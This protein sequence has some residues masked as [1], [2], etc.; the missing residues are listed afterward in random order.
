MATGYFPP[1]GGGSG[2]DDVTA[3]KNQLLAGYTAITS[4]SA[5]EPIEGTIPTR[6]AAN[7]TAAGSTVT[8]ASGYYSTAVSKAVAAGTA[9]TPATTL[10]FAPAINIDAATGKITATVTGS[11]N[12]TPQCRPDI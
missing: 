5:D 12:I 9:T 2:S 10:T 3:T 7:L 1:M 4:D 11:S 6:S 8:A